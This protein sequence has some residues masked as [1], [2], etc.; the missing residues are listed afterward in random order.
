[1]DVFVV[2]LR[3]YSEIEEVYAFSSR[4]LAEVFWN[5]KT[6]ELGPEWNVVTFA[7]NLDGAIEEMRSL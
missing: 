2:I 1:M 6:D 7:V 4:T 3:E 5:R